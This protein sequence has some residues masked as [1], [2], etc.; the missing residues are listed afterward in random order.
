VI[1]KALDGAKILEY[2]TMVSG[3]YC[4]K[5]M[6]DLGAE[7]I[8][9]ESPGTGD[10]ARKRGPFPGDDPHPEKSG[11][12]LYLNT[13]KC[14][15][16]LDPSKNEGQKIFMDLVKDMDILV[17]DRTSVEMEKIGL[18]FDDLSQLNPGLIIACLTPFGDSGP[19]RDY[20]A[21][22]I[23]LSH[24]SGQGFLLPI[25][26]LDPDRPPVKV[27]GHTSDADAGLVAAVGV[28]GA[29]FWKGITGK[30]QII[31]ISKQEAMMSVQRV[32]TVTYA[33]DNVVMSRSGQMQ[34]RMPGGIMPCK[35]GYVV[36]V[37]PEEHQWA[38]LME[39]IGDPDW[40]KEE[41]CRDPQLRVNHGEKLTALLIEWMGKH[42]KEEIFRKGQALSCP[43][44]PVYSSKDIV[45]SKQSEAR[46][47][48]T[49]M[50]HPEA[51]NMQIP[52][53]PYRFS[54]TPWRL[55]HPAPLLGQ[56]NDTIYIQRLGYTKEELDKLKKDGVI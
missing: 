24:V 5:L 42:E 34:R 19:Y 29:L 51:G 10:E 53:S 23:N 33:N 13:N 40:S 21:Q 46:E 28:L 9:I 14:G 8:K 38:A 18:G 26:T 32:E 55:R 45:E 52:T 44:A 43:V 50:T 36:T 3:P 17:V 54:K 56:H 6:A 41:W 11:L 47:L 7:V 48:F 15:I 16:T 39:L 1:Q 2:C 30:G 35:D 12:F 31:D 22:E 25:P 27:G 49:E 4:T 37:T 20:K